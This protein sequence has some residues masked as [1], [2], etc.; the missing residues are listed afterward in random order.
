MWERRGDSAVAP[1]LNCRSAADA[2]VHA[3][4]EV[5][6]IRTHLN[7]VRAILT[8]WGVESRIVDAPDIL[9]AMLQH[10]VRGRKGW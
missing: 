4:N 8:D 9:P 7:N 10:L 5:P 3:T 2:A 6:A 1:F